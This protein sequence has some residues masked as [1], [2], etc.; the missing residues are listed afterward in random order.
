MLV[1]ATTVHSVYLVSVWLRGSLRPAGSV[2]QCR[3]SSA[4]T[5][6]SGVMGMST[7]V[8]TAL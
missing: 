4:V 1:D 8:P 6:F 5:R 7:Q 2:T 3:E